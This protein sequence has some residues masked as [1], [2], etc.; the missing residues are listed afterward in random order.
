MFVS[1]RRFN[2]DDYL[3]FVVKLIQH[4]NDSCVL[5]NL[6]VFTLD[7]YYEQS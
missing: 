1:K 5:I 2:N 4:V 6:D 7:I 3:E